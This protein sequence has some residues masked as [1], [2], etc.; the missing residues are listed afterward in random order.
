MT[1]RKSILAVLPYIALLSFVMQIVAVMVSWLVCVLFPDSGVR[2]LLSQEGIRWMVGK[3]PEVMSTDVLLSLLYIS[4]AIG[5]L[6]GSGLPACLMPHNINAAEDGEMRKGEMKEEERRNEKEEMGEEE[7]EKRKEKGERGIMRYFR[8]VWNS[9]DTT[10]HYAYSNRIGFH[11]SIVAAVACL[12]LLLYLVAGPNTI[13]L[14]ATG[15]F[16]GS[17][18]ISGLVPLLSSIVIIVAVV[19]GVCASTLRS[20]QDIFRIMTEGVKAFAPLFVTYL[21]VAQCYYCM[22][23]VLGYIPV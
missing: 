21:F 6:F 3:L 9:P 23:Y 8:F 22:L 1:V 4:L 11:M 12:S 14:S 19:Y 5:T 13:L 18:I 17:S 16:A 10:S 20:L 2:S 15:T 7:G